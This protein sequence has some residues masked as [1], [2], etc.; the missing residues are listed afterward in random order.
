MRKLYILT[1]MAA[2]AA[3]GAGVSAETVSP[4]EAR[5]VADEFLGVR[6][7]PSR[8]V[9]HGAKGAAA[10]ERQPYYVFNSQTADGGFVIVSGNT[11]ARK[12]LGQVRHRQ[13]PSAGGRP[14]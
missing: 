6:T 13:H 3:G 8:I 11:G 10:T 5:R 9:R 7:Q 14:P 12:I 1:V 4:D 2:L